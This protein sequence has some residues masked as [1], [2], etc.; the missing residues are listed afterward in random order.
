MLFLSPL[1]EL[2]WDTLRAMSDPTPTLSV[3]GSVNLGKPWYL[4]KKVWLAVIGLVAV[5]VTTITGK[6]ET[7]GQIVAMISQ[8]AGIVSIIAPLILGIAHL[9]GKERELATQIIST[10]KSL[11]VPD[12][13][14]PVQPIPVPPAPVSP[15]QIPPGLTR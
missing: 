4:S 13:V 15:F 8:V 10:A 11:D 1:A 5:L 7:T 12:D 9:D 2:T 14:A 6:T 3:T